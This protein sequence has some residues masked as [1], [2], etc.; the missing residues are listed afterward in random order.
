MSFDH[1]KLLG[2]IR[3]CGYTQ[4]SL[5]K[6]IKMNVGTLTQKLKNRSHFTTEEMLAIGELL[7]ISSEE[8]GAYFF[9]K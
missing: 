5:A 8:I 1:S 2:R 7:D 9:K 6:A 3:E 4:K